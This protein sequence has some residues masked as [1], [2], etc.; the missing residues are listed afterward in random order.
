V[1]SVVVCTH[2]RAARLAE[3]LAS[4]RGQTM[5]AEAYEVLIADNASHDDTPEVAASFCRELAHFRYLPV[6]RLGLSVA[7]NAGVRAAAGSYVA[8]IDDDAQAAPD[9]L[10][11][12]VAGFQGF[13]ATPMAVGG[14][15]EPWWEGPVP[16]W[17]DEVFQRFLA[18]GLGWS[19]EP[20]FLAPPQWICEANSAYQR[21][22]LL[23]WPW[24]EDLGRKGTSLLS[25]ENLVNQRIFAA[26][27]RI[28]FDPR[29]LVRHRVSAHRLTKGWMRR[30]H[31]WQGISEAIVVARHPDVP[32]PRPDLDQE[33]RP[34]SR[35]QWEAL[36]D[37]ARPAA[38]L[39]G[40]CHRLYLLGYL[41]Q[42]AGLIDGR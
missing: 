1:I 35:E 15:I 26:G 28:Y 7:R 39:R 31:F 20:I 23:R 38:E 5:P 32:W 41:L 3:C 25:N 11:R 16:D 6:P 24:P 42:S 4:L 36:F 2:D 8:Y 37:D 13:A 33:W 9:W 30:R 12:L 10:Q 27:G 18:A 21:E 17:M 14:E 22:V 40:A 34:T 29:A 19:R